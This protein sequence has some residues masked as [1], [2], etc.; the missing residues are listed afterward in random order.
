MPSVKE[1]ERT[2]G[3][4]TLRDCQMSEFGPR[5]EF[6]FVVDPLNLTFSRRER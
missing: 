4:S 6:L 1:N 2:L 5:H 3:F